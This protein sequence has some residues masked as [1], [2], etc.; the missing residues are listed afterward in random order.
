MWGNFLEEFDTDQSL[1]SKFDMALPS[2]LERWTQ[3]NSDMILRVSHA[4]DGTHESLTEEQIWM[5]VA[6]AFSDSWRQARG[7]LDAAESEIERLNS[8]DLA[9]LGAIGRALDSDEVGAAAEDF[10]TALATFTIV[11]EGLRQRDDLNTLLKVL[12]VQ[13]R[14]LEQ[15]IKQTRNVKA[16]AQTLTPDFSVAIK[17]QKKRKKSKGVRLNGIFRLYARKIRRHLA[18]DD[19]P[20]PSAP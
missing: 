16:A 18:R 3:K 7:A 6:A 19:A 17:K 5:L 4:L 12:L 1:K 11:N 8:S 9:S 13:R 2:D 10:H 15:S 14:M 20:K